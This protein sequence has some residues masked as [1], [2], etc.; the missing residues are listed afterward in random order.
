MSYQFHFLTLKLFNF[1]ILPSEPFKFAI[2]TENSLFS[3][4]PADL[5]SWT[6]KLP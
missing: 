4:P 2:L 1:A 3:A 6:T 5:Q